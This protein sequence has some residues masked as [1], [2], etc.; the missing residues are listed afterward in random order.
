[1][2]HVTT[3]GSSITADRVLFEKKAV[4]TFEEVMALDE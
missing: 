2:F 4:P 3:T 1:M